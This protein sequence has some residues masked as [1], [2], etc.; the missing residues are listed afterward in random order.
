M[1]QEDKELLLKDL[2]GRVP[3]RVKCKYDDR[4][5]VNTLSV[6]FFW[7]KIEG[8]ERYVNCTRKYDIENIKPYLFPLSS[9]NEEQKKTLKVMCD[10]NDE[11]ADAQ[12][13]LVLYQKHFVMKT[14]V[15]DWLNENHFDYRGLIEKGLANDATGL[16]IY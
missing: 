3:Y 1:T 4:L 12:S 13:I 2:C 6:D 16:N 7:E 10:W 8:Y 14:D 5:I 9:M 15:I 11:E